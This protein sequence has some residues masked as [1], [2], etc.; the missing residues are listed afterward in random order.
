MK[1]VLQRDARA[2]RVLNSPSN[3]ERP[4]KDLFPL[5]QGGPLLE[6]NYH[7]NFLQ[8]NV[9]SEDLTQQADGNIVA[10]EVLQSFVGKRVS[11]RAKHLL[12]AN[13]SSFCR[14]PVDAASY[15]S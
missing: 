14:I 3:F 7:R 4:L 11:N 8:P 10:P 2:E 5:H 9:L 1:P 13:G 6:R 12:P 15:I